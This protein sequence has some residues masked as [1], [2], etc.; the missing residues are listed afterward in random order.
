MHGTVKM[1]GK[2]VINSYF[3][4]QQKQH[5]AISGQSTRNPF[6]F[7]FLKTFMMPNYDLTHHGAVLDLTCN[8]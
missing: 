1:V 8:S 2:K 7:W 6:R 4:A 3:S 5:L